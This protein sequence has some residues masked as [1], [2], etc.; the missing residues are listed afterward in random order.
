MP[1]LHYNTKLA[2]NGRIYLAAKRYR[3]NLLELVLGVAY[4]R[5]LGAKFIAWP[6]LK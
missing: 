6:K 2:K 1:S 3:L 5:S 4:H